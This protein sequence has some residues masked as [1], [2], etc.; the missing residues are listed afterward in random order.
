MRSL[1][2]LYFCTVLFGFILWSIESIFFLI[3]T[4]F[5][6]CSLFIAN[7]RP[8]KKKKYMTL[9]VIDSLIPS[10]M[11][12]HIICCLRQKL[13]TARFFQIVIGISVLPLALGYLSFVVNKL[14]RKPLKGALI[15]TKQKLYPKFV[16]Q[17]T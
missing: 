10:N 12:L 4:F 6:R 17:W 5:G 1:A 7:V 11:A 9:S 2:S 15:M 3:P 16:L 8:Y 13:H 14:F